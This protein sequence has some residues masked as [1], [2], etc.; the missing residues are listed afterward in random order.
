MPLKIGTRMYNPPCQVQVWTCLQYW[1]DMVTILLHLKVKIFLNAFE[2]LSLSFTAPTCTCGLGYY[3]PIFSD[4]CRTFL[5]Y[6]DPK[7]PSSGAV[8]SCVAGLLF[9][10]TTCGCNH[11]Y[12]TTCSTECT[13]LG[14][15]INIINLYIFSC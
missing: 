8:K 12:A 3:R 5:H 10:L 9:S 15:H 13:D 14:K 7:D 11:A 1:P 4:G 2:Y 6:T